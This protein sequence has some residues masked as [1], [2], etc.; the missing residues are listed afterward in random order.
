MVWLRFPSGTA[1]FEATNL[2]LQSTGLDKTI[3]HFFAGIYDLLHPEMQ[4]GY[5]PFKYNDELSP[6]VREPVTAN[7]VSIVNEPVFV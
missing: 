5:A 3:E 6:F 4:P 1:A 7:F 2:I